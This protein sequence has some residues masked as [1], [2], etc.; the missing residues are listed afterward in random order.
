MTL[1]PWSSL[2]ITG[3]AGSSTSSRTSCLAS[4]ADIPRAREMSRMDAPADGRAAWKFVA[5]LAVSFQCARRSQ[6]VRGRRCGRCAIE[7]PGS[8]SYSIRQTARIMASI[9]DGDETKYPP[10]L[11]VD[12]EGE[13]VEMERESVPGLRDWLWSRNLD[14]HFE[15]VDRWCVEMGAADFGEVADSSEELADFL[16]DALTDEERAVLLRGS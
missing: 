2:A 13:R 1:H 9:D 4:H 16:G 12:A 6:V 15:A 5:C 11:R 14:R 8:K 7:G 10:S 3:T